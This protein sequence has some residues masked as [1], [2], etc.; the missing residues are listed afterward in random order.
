MNRSQ[1]AVARFITKDGGATTSTVIHIQVRPNGGPFQ[2]VAV[3]DR[4]DVK[5]VFI[6]WLDDKTLE[7]TTPEARWFKKDR[8]VWIKGVGNVLVRYDTP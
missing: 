1:T 3:A 2:L 8:L 5:L 7:V 6:R 4:S